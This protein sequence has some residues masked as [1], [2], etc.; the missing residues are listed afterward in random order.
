MKKIMLGALVALSVVLVHAESKFR[1]PGYE[2]TVLQRE[3]LALMRIVGSPLSFFTEGVQFYNE[4]LEATGSSNP[5][6]FI[7][8][9]TVGGPFMTC[10]EAIGGVCE[11]ISF[12]QFK[13][14]GYPWEISPNDPKSVARIRESK[15]RERFEREAASG[16]DFIGELIGVAAGAAVGAVV[17]SAHGHHGSAA[18]ASYNVPVGNSSRGSRR[19]RHSSCNGTGRCNV[20]NGKGYLGSDPTNARLRCRSCGGSGSCCACNGGYVYVN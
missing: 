5:F 9:F 7:G 15:E 20:C 11:L 4:N 3:G 12:Q 17:S 2:P 1:A 8:G 6:S 16:S 10:F 19:V 18:K 13:S 14:C